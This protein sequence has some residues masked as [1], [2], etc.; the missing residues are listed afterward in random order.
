[1]LSLLTPEQAGSLLR[2][3]SAK[4]WGDTKSKL[5]DLIK[6]ILEDCNLDRALC[7]I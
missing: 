2:L 4:D 7:K 6:K 1:M 3:L 5:P